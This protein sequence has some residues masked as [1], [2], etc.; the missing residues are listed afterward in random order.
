MD[1]DVGRRVCSLSGAFSD[2][3]RYHTV[4]RDSGMYKV[5]DSLTARAGLETEWYISILTRDIPR[6][7]LP[8]SPTD[9]SACR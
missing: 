4:K 1:Q 3:T 9:P 6:D 8:H 7:D 5:F 2:K